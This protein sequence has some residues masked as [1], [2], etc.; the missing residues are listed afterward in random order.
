[1]TSVTKQTALGNGDSRDDMHGD[2]HEKDNDDD[3]TQRNHALSVGDSK[4]LLRMCLAEFGD[5]WSGEL[6]DVNSSQLFDVLEKVSGL[7]SDAVTF[8]MIFRASNARYYIFRKMVETNLKM[9]C[10]TMSEEARVTGPVADH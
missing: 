2:V 4:L 10:N 7:N 8:P 3:S 5:E 1:M 9:V 6:A